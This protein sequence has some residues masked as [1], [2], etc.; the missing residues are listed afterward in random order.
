MDRLL[1]VQDVCD[2][3]QV[4]RSWVYT[5]VR[6]GELKRIKLGREFRFRQSDLDAFLE[7]RVAG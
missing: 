6:R 2:L 3:L 4:R 7:Q 1:T 5:V